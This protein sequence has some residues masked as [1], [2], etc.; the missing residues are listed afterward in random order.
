MVHTLTLCSDIFSRVLL[1]Y[2]ASC[3]LSPTLS[4]IF[5]LVKTL[6]KTIWTYQKGRNGII[7]ICIHTWSRS[8]HELRE[9]YKD[10]DIAVDIKR[11][12]WIG[13]VVRMDQGRAVKKI[14]ESK[15]EVSRRRGRPTLRWLEFVEKDLG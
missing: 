1:Y 3:V 11:L 4:T 9:L 13:H 6:G 14:F 15:S 7:C 12:E 5:K 2:A 10:L 8:D